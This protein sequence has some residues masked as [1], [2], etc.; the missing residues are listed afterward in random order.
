MLTIFKFHSGFGALHSIEMALLKI[1]NDCKL[2]V[3]S[4]KAL[5][6]VLL[7]LNVAF[8][9]ADHQIWLHKGFKGFILE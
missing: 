1:V 3:Y 7:D 5:I 4:N 6:S 8:D 2:I 9:I